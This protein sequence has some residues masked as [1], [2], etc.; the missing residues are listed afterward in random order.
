MPEQSRGAGSVFTLKDGRRGVIR[1]VTMGDAAGLLAMERA[2]HRAGEGV[3]RTVDQLERSVPAFR[4]KLREWVSGPRGGTHGA[5]LVC[6]VNG[7]VVGEGVIRRMSPRR[8]R[9]VAHVSVE[10][11]PEFQG[12]GIGR[13]LMLAML[14]WAERVPKGRDGGILRVDLD[15]FAVNTRAVR[16]YRSLGFVI[17]GTRKDFVRFE[18]GSW[19]DDH[20]MALRL[21]GSGRRRGAVGG[22]RA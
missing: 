5:L 19:S 13:A 7:R 9:H 17:E 12:L 11:H 8:V 14:G 18:D 1:P 15:V 10:V 16:L 21:D 20:I 3:V 22:R 4:S 6:D 2:V